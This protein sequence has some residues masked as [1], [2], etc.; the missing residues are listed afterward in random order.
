M[1]RRVI[2]AIAAILLA[3]VGAVVLLGYVGHADQRA[4]AGMETV[5]VFVVTALIPEGTT[6]DALAKLVAIEGTYRPW[7]SPPAQCPV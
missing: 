7:R 4:L 1:K 5:S 2:A 6:A 3:G